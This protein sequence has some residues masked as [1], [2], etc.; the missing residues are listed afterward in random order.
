MVDVFR[1]QKIRNLQ[2]YLFKKE[3]QSCRKNTS[4]T[5]FVLLS[6]RWTTQKLELNGAKSFHD[7]LVLTCVFFNME[8]LIFMIENSSPRQDNTLSCCR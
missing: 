6:S 7:A 4:G 2:N 1:K 3:M 8:I 5:E